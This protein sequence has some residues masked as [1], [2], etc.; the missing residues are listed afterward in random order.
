[1]IRRKIYDTIKLVRLLQLID[2]CQATGSS[3]AAGQSVEEEFLHLLET[4][5]VSEA[6]LPFD[7]V[8]TIADAVE[9]DQY[10]FLE[11]HRMSYSRR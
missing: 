8:I 4:P 11:A 2:H 3:T 5:K 10:G 6:A 7:Y 9:D 1:M